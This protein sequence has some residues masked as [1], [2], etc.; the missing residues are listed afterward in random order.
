[1]QKISYYVIRAQI[2]LL[3]PL[4]AFKTFSVAI[5]NTSKMNS[6]DVYF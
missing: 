4:F 6:K 5:K 3:G 1:M 2:K